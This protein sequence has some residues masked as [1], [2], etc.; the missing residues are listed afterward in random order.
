MIRSGRD[1]AGKLFRTAA[2]RVPVDDVALLRQV[3]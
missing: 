1:E 3:G 2:D